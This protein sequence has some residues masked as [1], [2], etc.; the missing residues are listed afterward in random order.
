M[1]ETH[2]GYQRPTDPALAALHEARVAFANEGY[3]PE[4][5]FTP[6]IADLEKPEMRFR[7]AQR[8]GRPVG[9]V[10]LRL[11]PSGY[12][13]VKALYIDEA[14]RGA[15]LARALM[16]EIEDV[17][18]AEGV[19]LLRLETG[20]HHHG[21]LAF[22]PREGWHEIGRFDPY[23]PNDTSIFFEKRLD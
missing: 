16:A 15:G 11:D 19:T 3:Q 17:A 22:Y 8:G 12:G 6:P 10:A 5:C 23:P 13:E 21:A 9:M 20:I 2:I 7:V 1:T 14:A 4:E 18:R